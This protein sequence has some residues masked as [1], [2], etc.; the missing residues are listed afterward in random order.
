MIL[1][2]LLLTWSPSVA[3]CDGR[4]LL[5]P[6]QVHYVLPYLVR[7]MVVRADCADEFGQPQAC[8]TYT[9]GG[10]WTTFEAWMIVDA[11]SDPPVGVVYDIQEPVAVNPAGRSDECAE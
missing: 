7:E 2:A 3:G 8:A 1:L 5:F 11:Q 10:E 9:G 6:E 4:A